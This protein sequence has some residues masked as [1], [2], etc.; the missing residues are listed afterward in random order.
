LFINRVNHGEC[1]FCC[2]KIHAACVLIMLSSALKEVGFARI[3]FYHEWIH[4]SNIP[5]QNFIFIPT[6]LSILVI[7]L[8][9][10][11]DLDF[12]ICNVPTLNFVYM[13]SK[14]I[15]PTV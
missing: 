7:K 6:C 1:L 10:S 3:P 8:S 11:L 5:L 15:S 2:V 14:T 9:F 13:C 12:L 4:I